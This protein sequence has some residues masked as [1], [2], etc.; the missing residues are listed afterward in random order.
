MHQRFTLAL[1]LYFL[2]MC[3]GAVC[4]AGI[5]RT[6]SGNAGADTTICQNT[7]TLY[8]S[9]T[10]SDE[11]GTWYV[12]TGTGTLTDINMHN[13]A[14]TC[15]IN[16]INVLA[17]EILNTV[18]SIAT[19]DT[20][21]IIQGSPNTANAGTDK[22]ICTANTT[23][24]G[25]TPLYGSTGH[26]TVVSGLGNFI[27]PS[28][29]NTSLTGI[30]IGHNIYQWTLTKGLCTS[31]STVSVNY[32]KAN[33]GS[34]IEVCG[35]TAQLAAA[36]P[37]VNFYYWN[38]SVNYTFDDANAPNT[39][40]RGLQPGTNVLAWT[41][42]QFPSGCAS[43]SLLTVISNIVTPSNAG[44]NQT[45]LCTDSTLLT[46]NTP[47]LGSGRWYTVTGLANITNLT[48]PGSKIK[49]L[50]EGQTILEWRISKSI[51]TSSSYVTLQN[52]RPTKANAGVDMLICVSD[53]VMYANSPTQGTGTW[54][55]LGVGGTF[56]NNTLSGS[57]LN[58]ITSG[59]STYVWT[60]SHGGC[61]DSRDTI[62]ITKQIFQPATVSGLKYREICT[63]TITVLAQNTTAGGSW[64]RISGSGNIQNANNFKTLITNITTDGI[65]KFE[66]Q[67]GIGGCATTYD[68]IQVN[69]N[70]VSPANAGVNTAICIDSLILN[71]NIPTKGT[72]TW[73]VISGTGILTNASLHNT[74][75]KNLSPNINILQWQ[76]VSAHCSSMSNVSITNNRPTTSIT[77]GNKTICNNSD[78]IKANTPVQGSGYWQLSR[79]G[80]NIIN[81]LSGISLVNN[82]K[83]GYNSFRWTISKGACQ[84]V[85]SMSIVNN[86]PSAAIAMPDTFVCVNQL[87]IFAQNPTQGIG[88]WYTLSTAGTITNHIM[89]TTTITGMNNGLNTFLWTVSHLG[90]NISRDTVRITNN[91][92][93]V[94]IAGADSC[95][96]LP[97]GNQVRF[98]LYGNQPTFFGET[99]TWRTVSAPPGSINYP[100]NTSIVTVLGSGGS[101][102]YRFAW[103]I[104]D[105]TAQCTQEDT[106]AITVLPQS[107][108][109]ADQCLVKIQG[110]TAV[111]I[112]LTP[113]NTLKPAQ[114]EIGRWTYVNTP[115]TPPLGGLL[116][117]SVTGIV[118]GLERGVHTFRFTVQN[119]N[120]LSCISND[121]LLAS[122][123]TKADVGVTNK[124]ICLEGINFTGVVANA[125]NPIN[126]AVGGRGLWV[127]STAGASVTQTINA[128]GSVDGSFSNLQAGIN[129]FY[130]SVY[131]IYNP[132][133]L[134]TD[135]LF[136]TNSTSPIA[137]NDTLL[138]LNTSIT[139]NFARYNLAGNTFNTSSSESGT[140]SI[141]PGNP[142]A[143]ITGRA[144]NLAT[145]SG[146]RVGINSFIWNI[147]NTVS[148]CGFNDTI[149]IY[150]QTKAIAYTTTGILYT[151]SNPGIALTRALKSPNILA[152]ITGET[153]YWSIE[154]TNAPQFPI[155]SPGST[156]T[157]TVYSNLRRGISIF[158]WTIFNP[159]WP[160]SY[161]NYSDISITVMTE[162]VAGNDICFSDSANIYLGNR[163]TVSVRPSVGEKFVWTSSD[164]A[165]SLSTPGD[166]IPIIF[167]SGIPAGK[168]SF[169]FTIYNTFAGVNAIDSDTIDIYKITQPHAGTDQF[170]ITSTPSSIVA[171]LNANTV[172]TT[173]GETG[174]WLI[175]APLS[176]TAINV[177]NATVS[178]LQIGVN[179]LTWTTSLAGCSLRDT[180]LVNTQNKAQ[181]GNQI[182]QLHTGTG[183]NIQVRLQSQ[184]NINTLRGE[185]GKWQYIQSNN[186]HIPTTTSGGNI[187]EL[188]IN[189]LTRGVYTYRWT[190]SSSS[191]AGQNYDDIQITV[192]T[193]AKTESN[194]C[195]IDSTSK[196][197]G[198]GQYSINRPSLG[199]IF[200]WTNDKSLPMT[201]SPNDS[202]PKMMINGLAIGNTKLY[203]KT[204][205]TITGFFDTD[206]LMITKVTNPLLPND[207]S[208]CDTSYHL[209]P[210]YVPNTLV[211]ETFNLQKISGATNTTFNALI[212]NPVLSPLDTGNN[213][214]S[215]TITHGLCKFADTITVRN[216]QPY[217]ASITG[218]NSSCFTVNSLTGN[219]PK[220]QFPTASGYWKILSQPTAAGVNTARM[221]DSLNKNL[222]IT[223]MI[224]TG[225][226]YFSWTIHN[227][228]CNYTSAPF[229]VRRDN[230]ISTNVGP[231][232]VEL[233]INKYVMQAD[234][235]PE[236]VEGT[237]SQIDGSG[238]VDPMQI[239]NPKATITG[240]DGTPAGLAS[241][242][243]WTV[244]KGECTSPPYTVRITTYLPPAIALITTENNM[245]LCELDS[246]YLNSVQTYT[247][248]TGFAQWYIPNGSGSGNI[249]NSNLPASWL[250]N[251]A[252]GNNTIIF[253]RK[254]LSTSSCPVY[255]DTISLVRYRKPQNVSAGDNQS[256][257]G[258]SFI[259]SAQNPGTLTGTWYSLE[260]TLTLTA[261]NTPLYQLSDIAQGNYKFKWKVVDG[262]CADSSL[263]SYEVQ[264][265]VSQALINTQS[266][267]FCDTA[268]TLIKADTP[269]KGR[270]KWYSM[271]SKNIIVNDTM[272][273][274][275][276]Y[277]KNYGVN[278]F[279]WKV[280][281]GFCTSLDSIQIENIAPPTSAS[282][283]KDTIVCTPNIKLTGNVPLVGHSH[284][285]SLSN[286]SIMT[287]IAG[288]DLYIEKLAL[289]SN[290]FVYSVSTLGCNTSY[291]TVAVRN[292]L[293]QNV[294]AGKDT[295][296]CL[297]TLTMK[298]S[299]LPQGA[300]G[301][302][303]LVS[304]NVRF[305]DIE[306]PSTRIYAVSKGNNVL[307][308]NVTNGKCP[309]M[310]ANVTV[311]NN[312]LSPITPFASTA[313]FTNATTLEA[314]TP[315]HGTGKW[316]V[317]KG[318]ATLDTPN[319]A[320]TE[321]R[322]LTVGDN[323]FRWVVKA[324]GCD[325]VYSDKIVTIS[326]IRIPKGFSPNNDDKNPYFEISGIEEYPNSKLEVYNRWGKIVYSSD[327]YKNNW[328]G[329]GINSQILNNDTYLYI[330]SLSDGRTIRDYV[331]INR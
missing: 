140:W 16:S 296:I 119:T 331:T 23:L 173:T 112:T 282:A 183:H 48:L 13:S 96:I 305:S 261:I 241:N 244:R 226:Y 7:I 93:T 157:E 203:M 55:V 68:T 145:V 25:N 210:S 109:G 75:V 81:S 51:C 243:S 72:G 57:R 62:N 262:S 180:L 29:R 33:A 120:A 231:T 202:I 315:D 281:E 123:I 227:Q 134:D 52:N 67:F 263:V 154:S 103:R 250:T 132:G 213:I 42:Q 320:V 323:V 65:S 83:L 30:N 310:S 114:G 26:W 206:S 293:I 254:N 216:N 117:N 106:L 258:S 220:L 303:S 160:P 287:S 100:P 179:I 264:P 125:N 97:S 313:I 82:L 209:T 284:W 316:L 138:L 214:F 187:N 235:L 133:C 164:P 156:L 45:T 47:A 21:T 188:Y 46:A 18:T 1:R 129:K 208:L 228:G 169:Y 14:F 321:A 196:H 299:A 233:C 212:Y 198:N 5:H 327:N 108:A 41:T 311:T 270:G 85:D 286:D 167:A 143:S 159:T 205:N 115:F 329:K 84:S 308:W 301:T 328:D 152:T 222:R 185:A 74:W 168:T 86:S 118:T 111:N 141:K 191:F 136:I 255:R 102:Y 240:I 6:M 230:S 90:C 113:L 325:S 172:N 147:S 239:H 69:H 225:D 161:K 63:D 43:N 247:G 275:M 49:N 78:T 153:G 128:N 54:S 32:N 197:I 66:W 31:S 101:G 71:A 207:L 291:D 221:A 73:H 224:E 144:F 195:I 245:Q 127:S 277:I 27:N 253:E 163:E 130:F 257:C 175:L 174:R 8:A 279:V 58:G 20:I 324:K 181:A 211:G 146:M 302:W 283:G 297:D 79:G 104:I 232:T 307:N 246:V 186:G 215:Y 285:Q 56:D 98:F 148:G 12:L 248:Y 137:G 105:A 189:D 4:M 89:N 131:N 278:T 218:V 50:P 87:N 300:T 17:W 166:S 317:L 312:G 24:S 9:P 200:T 135:S 319:D 124:R 155:S 170:I 61:S 15:T 37:T 274:S 158:R 76:I 107:N 142:F 70:S 64:R 295:L 251:I 22:I 249:I 122:L 242:W 318:N 223:Q 151:N 204:T 292:L 19:S 265:A 219:N 190:M 256:I 80:G 171:A 121:E 298:A 60:I 95:V 139:G 194:I 92:V 40:V 229:A 252:Y 10:G 165:I 99:G 94:P 184:N 276:L 44:S 234:T 53:T 110:V 330:L 193:K 217:F 269:T 149:D 294:Y 280:S 116:L 326:D 77:L 304:G 2:S 150:V 272:P 36:T 273:S 91:K 306:N 34:T 11:V 178:G 289:G 176:I 309:P 177:P 199:E 238:T 260:P 267:V 162:A 266:S 59:V 268:S 201:Y 28:L 192:L 259:L 35:D 236:N 314:A 88:R 271:Q 126:Q 322:S 38:F 3:V 288:V 39:V 182:L 290:L 237:W